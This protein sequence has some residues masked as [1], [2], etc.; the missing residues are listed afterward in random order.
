MDGL[1]KVPSWG[2]SVDVLVK[3]YIYGMAIWPR[4]NH[5]W[6]YEGQRS[7]GLAI[8]MNHHAC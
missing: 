4:V 6:S 8:G 2:S 7:Q 3:E 1:A 5:C